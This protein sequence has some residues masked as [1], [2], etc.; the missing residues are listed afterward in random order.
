MTTWTEEYEA[1]KQFD[2]DY[3][4]PMDCNPEKRRFEVGILTDHQTKVKC[5][6]KTSRW[7]DSKKP[8]LTKK[9]KQDLKELVQNIIN[10]KYR[11]P[12]Q[13][14]EILYIKEI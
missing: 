10:E 1:A 2:P 6:I 3:I 12:Y 13:V 14:T 5:F 8:I 4:D 11:N 9:V 7:G